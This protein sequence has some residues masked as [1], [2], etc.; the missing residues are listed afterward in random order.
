MKRD[1]NFEHPND[2]RLLVRGLVKL[3]GK[4]RP[5]G[6]SNSR[7]E[8]HQTTYQKPSAIHFTILLANDS[9]IDSRKNTKN[10]QGIGIAI[11][12]ETESAQL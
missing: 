11:L 8:F 10:C 4:A 2:G 9:G 5:N 12:L 6:L 7:K 1:A 3:P